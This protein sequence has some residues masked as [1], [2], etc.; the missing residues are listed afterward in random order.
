MK[1]KH[2][3]DYETI[4][5]LIADGAEQNLTK[6]CD[7]YDGGKC[8]RCCTCPHCLAYQSS[9][10]YMGEVARQTMLE[11][12]VEAVR[13]LREA[14]EVLREFVG[15]NIIDDVRSKVADARA[16]G[17]PE[18]TAEEQAKDIGD[19][20]FAL[21]LSS[22]FNGLAAVIKQGKT[23]N[24]HLSIWHHM[25]RP[26][27]GTAEGVAIIARQALLHL[28]RERMLQGKAPLT[29]N[30][31]G[32]IAETR[33]V[34]PIMVVHRPPEDVL[35]AMEEMIEMLDEPPQEFDA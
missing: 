28:M 3:H 4:D 22:T 30:K 7:H 35:K 1:H 9:A 25:L 27:D 13:P 34:A 20:M 18:P 17:L 26:S 14:A 33:G 15:F 32:A 6:P 5:A 11:V 29:I 16:E 31:R 21:S 24:D 12:G 10:F 19:A 23:E 8:P 2:A